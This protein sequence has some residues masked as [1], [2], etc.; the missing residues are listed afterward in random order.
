MKNITTNTIR[1]L[2]C[3]LFYSHAY[4]QDVRH[5]SLQEAINTGVANSKQLKA[6]N[7]GIE[8]AS[9]H[10]REL[11]NMKLPEINASGAYMRML[12]PSFDLKIPL[13]GGNPQ[14]TSST[15]GQGAKALK[16]NQMM[17]ASVNASLPLFSGFR[18]RNGIE[19]AQL[20]KRATELDVDKDKGKVILNIITSYFNLYKAQSAIKLLNENLKQAQSR[21]KDFTNLEKNGLLARNDLMKAEL[22]QS[23]VELTIAEAENN[24]K[25]SQ[26]SI[27]LLLG[28]PENT[29]LELENA[30]PPSLTQLQPLEEWQKTAIA[31]RA[32]LLALQT[33]QQAASK[34]T[35]SI[36]GE[37]Y[38]SVALTGGYIAGYIPNILTLANA[39]NIGIGLSYNISSLYKTGTKVKQAKA[40]EQQLYWNNLEAQDGIR[41]QVVK[42]YEDY[43]QAM[44]KITLYEKAVDQANENYRITKNKFDN[45]LETTTN[46]LDADVLQLQARLNYEFAKADAVIAYNKLAETAGTIEKQSLK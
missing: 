14:D 23:N 16:V 25:V 30:G 37:Y 18:I 43:N 40:Q 6:G 3:V 36:K 20:M 29:V 11:N 24:L 39:A 28:L 38:P 46:L 44:Q 21:V 12:Q 15:M 9:W 13:P 10:I 4:A 22:Q 26:Y 31:S 35:E 33:R 1:L 34:N 2:I 19:A 8:A 17:Y 27:N 7:A 5:L 41:V 42:A 45:S 32:D